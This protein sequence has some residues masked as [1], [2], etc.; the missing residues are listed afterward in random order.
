MSVNE[1]TNIR[2]GEGIRVTDRRRWQSARTSPIGDV[3]SE[4]VN[5]YYKMRPLFFVIANGGF[6]LVKW[7]M[8]GSGFR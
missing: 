2:L 7:F 5:S 8:L 4:R 1:G 3:G 6:Q